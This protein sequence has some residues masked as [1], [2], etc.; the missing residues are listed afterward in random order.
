M[1]ADS[2]TQSGHVTL[3]AM[4]DAAELQAIAA[5]LAQT[6]AR[7]REMLSL[8]WCAALADKLRGQ[9]VAAG[10]LPAGFVSVQC[11]A[12]E[13]SRDQ[14]WLVAPHQ[15]LSIPVA[16][17]VDDP[18]L[19]GWSDK[20]GT[21]FVQPPVAVL[22]QLVALRLH[23]DACQAHDGAL[24]VV[25]GSHLA[26]RIQEADKAHLKATRGEVVC[27]VAPG[28]GMAM[29]PLLLHASSKATGDSRRRVL[30]FVF[31]PAVLPFGMEW[32]SP[33]PDSSAPRSV[34]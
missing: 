23:I 3:P 17:R 13:K 10:L 26:G 16:R 25:P 8:P 33:E 22:A 27:P 19:S 14:N 29:R 6:M 11:T 15:D 28:G 2:F 31:G 7:P 1:Y 24:K 4:V 9:L 5:M 32:A 20:D 21:L 34:R 30:H 18:A 12:F